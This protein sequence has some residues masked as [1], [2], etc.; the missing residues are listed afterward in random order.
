MINSSTP[1][2]ENPIRLRRLN[3]FAMVCILAICLIRLLPFVTCFSDLADDHDAYIALAEGW[4]ESGIFGRIQR[5]ET[6]RPEVIPTAF[7]PPLYPWLLSWLTRHDFAEASAEMPF[8]STKLSL[9]AVAMFH[10]IIGVATCL[11][12]VSIA[13]HCMSSPENPTAAVYRSA[14]PSLAAY[15]VGLLCAVD[16]ILLRQSTLVMTETLATFLAVAIWLWW[17]K[18]PRANGAEMIGGGLLVGLAILCRPTFAVWAIGLFL[19]LILSN[20][21][22]R[23]NTRCDSVG[24]LRRAA[25]FVVAI[26]LTMAPWIVRNAVVFG[27]PIW[28]TTHGGYTL[29]LAN[30]PVLFQHYEKEGPSRIWDEAIFHE[31][32]AERAG[33]DLSQPAYWLDTNRQPIAL[34]EPTELESP[35]FPRGELVDDEVASKAAWATIARQPNIF[36]KAAFIRVGWLWAPAPA[37]MQSRPLIRVIIGSWYTIIYALA[38]AAFLICVWNRAKI[39]RFFWWNLA[40]AISLIVSLTAVHS[41]YWSNMRMRSV[42]MPAVYAIAVCCIWWVLKINV[43]VNSSGRG[44]TSHE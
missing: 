1:N 30:N 3:A 44:Q 25:L 9:A 34:S 4:S 27:Q 32:W 23:R 22:H 35:D 19:C 38:L 6:S 2:L 28:A 11:M 17:C 14:P 10:W 24:G 20:W 18:Y 7:R 29:L 39:G 12:S 36:L 16:P 13:A 21:K 15:L 40:P 37:S 33:H 43:R 8:G 41:V 42:A 31:R 5:A 26:A